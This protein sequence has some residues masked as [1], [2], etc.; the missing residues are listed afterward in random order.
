MS[1]PMH[2]CGERFMPWALTDCHECVM[3]L[4]F[5]TAERAQQFTEYARAAE[6]TEALL[7]KDSSH[8]AALHAEAARL[9]TAAA[10]LA[11]SA[12]PSRMPKRP[13]AFEEE[14]AAARLRARGERAL[15]RLQQ[16]DPAEYER[17]M[18]DITK[19]WLDA[20]APGL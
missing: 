13:T 19:R 4:A 10:D 1:E 8:S 6:R 17:V 16:T 9:T 7:G 20:G 15:D 5:R 11:A 18:A 14:Q 3:N 2:L 12:P